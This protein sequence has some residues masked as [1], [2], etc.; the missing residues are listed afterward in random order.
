MTTG[1]GSA[2]RPEAAQATIIPSCTERDFFETIYP[3]GRFGAWSCVYCGEPIEYRTDGTVLVGRGRLECRVEDLGGY[4]QLSPKNA[5]PG[6][7][8]R[9]CSDRIARAD[10]VIP[11]GRTIHCPICGDSYTSAMVTRWQGSSRVKGY[12]REGQADGGYA[13]DDELPVP[14]LVPVERLG[15]RPR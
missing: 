5:A 12:V 6:A 10:A 2:M 1:S 8:N 7:V 9:C 14:A 3:F 13:V 15:S 4:H 11:L